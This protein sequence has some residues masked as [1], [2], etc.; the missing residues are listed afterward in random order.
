LRTERVDGVALV[1]CCLGGF[2]AA[3]YAALHPQDVKALAVFALPF[4]SRPPFVPAVAESLARYY[5]NVPASWLRAA[6]NARVADPA[7]VPGFLAAELGEP[8][9][10]S[11]HASADTLALRRAFAS[12]LSSDV[13]FAG[14]LFSD[15]MGEA[16]GRGLFAANRLVV[17]GRRVALENIRCRVLNVCAKDDRLVPVAESIGFVQHAGSGQGVNL[18]VPGGHIGL[19]LSRAAHDSLWP[20]AARWLRGDQRAVAEIAAA[21]DAHPPARPTATDQDQFTAAK[22][23]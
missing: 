15:V 20:L 9:L 6:L 13:P 18:F 17:G 4:Q 1:G 14:R 8:E 10:A 16:F 22:S 5:G 23:L 21:T 12:W 2:L 7:A 11:P 19:M 3:V